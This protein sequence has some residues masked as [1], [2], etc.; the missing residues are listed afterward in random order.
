M[1]SVFTL[2]SHSIQHEIIH[3]EGGGLEM[4]QFAQLH[5]FS[6]VYFEVQLDA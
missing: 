3:R 4:D 6:C 2:V 1:F 5:P